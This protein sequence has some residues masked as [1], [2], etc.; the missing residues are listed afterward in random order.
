MTS[1]G[2]YQALIFALLLVGCI[3][4][5]HLVIHTG[6]TLLPES[7]TAILIGAVLG[8]VYYFLLDTPEQRAELDFDPEIFFTVLLP[9]IIFDAGYS[10]KRRLFFRNI[11]PI[12]ML[13]VVGTLISTAVIAIILA[14]AAQ[15]G[16]IDGETITTH[17]ILLF[18]ALIS[19][20]DP[21]G[22][23]AVLSSKEINADHT[24]Q[25]IIFGESVLNDAVAI[26]LFQTLL[27]VKNPSEL[28]TFSSICELI[29]D[30]L[31]ISISSI[32][33]GVSVALALS[34]LLRHYHFEQVAR[35][36]VCR[37]DPPSV[38]QWAAP[39]HVS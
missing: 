34:L 37:L 14:L 2:D 36:P 9:P 23:L 33:I 28:G 26:V 4:G 10:L 8:A 3:L 35:G 22:T 32:A 38:A 16:W 7:S 5:S 29:G 1:A 19:A 21:V 11:T 17:D 12:L 18:A 20:V 30:F 27:N 25:S 24:L 6:S 13:A 15:W 31:K 39:L